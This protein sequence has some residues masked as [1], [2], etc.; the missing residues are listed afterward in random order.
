MLCVQPE[1]ISVP[2]Q[3]LFVLCF[4]PARNYAPGQAYWNQDGIIRGKTT[5]LAVSPRVHGR[6]KSQAVLRGISPDYGSW[7]KRAYSSLG[8][9]SLCL[10]HSVLPLPCE[11]RRF[12]MGFCRDIFF[13]PV[14]AYRRSIWVSVQA[15]FLLVLLQVG[16]TGNLSPLVV[17]S[18]ACSPTKAPLR[19]SLQQNVQPSL[20][21][22]RSRT[23]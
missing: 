12:S 4:G 20:T 2:F 22:Q 10:G 14:Q 21:Q 19:S 17:Q 1:H 5:R 7:S 18:S 11:N 3:H 6:G 16:M 8:S 9:R 13:L 15:S 23:Y